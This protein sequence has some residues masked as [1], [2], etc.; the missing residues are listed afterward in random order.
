MGVV[1]GFVNFFRFVGGICFYVFYDLVFVLELF[2]IFENNGDIDFVF[3]M[4]VVMDCKLELVIWGI[5]SCLFSFVDDKDVV[6]GLVIF[7][8]LDDG[9]NVF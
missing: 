1:D 6:F 7:V 4:E 8:F 2:I 9:I 3:S 5:L